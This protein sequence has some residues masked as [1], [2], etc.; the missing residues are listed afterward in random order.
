[1][2]TQSVAVVGA[3][4]VGVSIAVLLAPQHIVTVIDIDEARLELLADRRSPIRDELIEQKLLEPDIQLSTT[5]IPAE[6]YSTADVVV[7]A[8]PTNFDSETGYFNTETV[9]QVIRD[10]A[11]IRPRATVV[12]KST[13]PVGFTQSMAEL[14]PGMTILFS[15]EFLREG[16]A[17]WDNLHPSRVIIGGPQADA[18]EFGDMLIDAADDKDAHVIVTSSNEAEAIKLFSNTYLAMRVAY[19]N[20]LDTFA[21]S[22][23]LD[24][25][26]LIT[27]VG[28]D[29]RIGSHYNN[30]SFGYGGYCLPKDVRQLRANYA[31][32]PQALIEATITSNDLRKDFITQDIMRRNPRVVGIYRLL[33]KTGSDNFRESSVQGII[34]RL[35]DTGVST[36]LYEPELDTPFFNGTPVTHD[37]DSMKSQADIIVTNRR[38]E[39]LEDVASKVYTRDLFTSD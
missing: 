33:M 23:Q 38:S 27:G 6:A 16:K 4:Y 13:V 26:L 5:T 3:G 12:I 21:A 24:A 1:M 17:L 34:Q 39:E 22:H 14:H 18:T 31:G 37:L 7:I 35:N 25:R 10:V 32:V 29:P 15:P 8:T 2:H 28:L 36:I 19:F 9:E 11:E 30:P 20:E